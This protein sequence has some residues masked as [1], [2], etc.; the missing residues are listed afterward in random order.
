[1]IS[2]LSSLLNRNCLSPISARLESASG[3]VATIAA[4]ALMSASLAGVVAGK[5]GREMRQSIKRTK[6][7]PAITKDR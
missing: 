2:A 7:T 6:A 4:A 5:A 1:M 3:L